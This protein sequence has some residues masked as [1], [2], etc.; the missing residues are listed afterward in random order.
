[1]VVDAFDGAFRFAGGSLG[2]D[3]TQMLQGV[4]GGHAGVAASANHLKDVVVLFAWLIRTNL[5]YLLNQLH[6]K[7]SC[8]WGYGEESPPVPHTPVNLLG[9]GLMLYA[10][11]RLL[12]RM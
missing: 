5:F 4:V 12:I 3:L 2:I 8:I 7:R 11:I 6:E 9:W 1:M 10:G